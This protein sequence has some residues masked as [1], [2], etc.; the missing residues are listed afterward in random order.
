MHRKRRDSQPAHKGRATL[1]SFGSGAPFAAFLKCRSCCSQQHRKDPPSHYDKS[2]RHGD[3]TEEVL[4]AGPLPPG[5]CLLPLFHQGRAGEEQ[6][7]AQQQDG[8]SH[9]RIRRQPA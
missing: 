9:D 1:S 6:E 3:G 4:D 2:G 5:G 8:P 7:N